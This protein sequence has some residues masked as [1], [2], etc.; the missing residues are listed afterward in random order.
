M[1][2]RVHFLGIAGSG[3]SAAA[4]IA[5]AQGFEV[6]G[7]DTNPV[8]EFT[9]DFE[10]GS[11]KGGHSKTHLENVDILAITPAVLSLDPNNEEL[12][13]AKEK[14]VEVLTWQ[15]FLGKYLIQDKTVIAVC[16]THG[17]STTTAM[18]G[19][20]LTNAGL[21]PTVELGAL[22]PY[23]GRNYRVGNGKYF[24]VEAD[25]FNDNFLSIK[26]NITVVTTIEMDHP[27]YFKNF[28][29]LKNSYENFL[30]QTKDTIVA[31]ISDVSIAEILKTLMKESGVKCIDYS[32]NELNLNLKV[33]GSFNQ[34]NASAAFQVGLLLGIDPKII[35]DSLEGFTGIGRRFE[36]LGQFKEAAVYSDFGHHPTE[37]KVTMEAAR[38]KFPDKE[39]WLIFEPH[40]F[41]RTKALF[42]DFVRVFKKLPV[43]K[44]VITD[45][46]PSREVDTGLIK[47]QH[48]VDSTKKENVIYASGEELK[49]ILFKEINDGDVVFFMGAGNI[50]TLARKLVS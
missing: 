43:D 6:T 49:E 29:D 16:G 28:Q 13:V 24:V 18:I 15:Q 37:I 26:P 32:K 27:E 7:C 17:K 2:K 4:A 48:L 3:A 22:L 44:I 30:L 14:G 36:H 12:V 41:S 38:E 5:K 47:S 10:K 20:L 45:I 40:M 42:D 19:K 31:N 8:N 46:Y 11:I 33:P 9:T 23:S 50:D 1:I 35:K 21:D 25:E 39:I 34:L